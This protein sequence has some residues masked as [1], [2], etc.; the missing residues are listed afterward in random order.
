MPDGGH[1]RIEPY[2]RYEDKCGDGLFY[3]YSDF[4]D[5]VSMERIRLPGKIMREIESLGYWL[6][7][8]TPA[9]RACAYRDPF[10]RWPIKWY[11]PSAREHIA[12][13]DRLC[14]LLNEQGVDIVRMCSPKP[15][16]IIYEDG[17]QIIIRRPSAPQ[18]TAEHFSA[19][20][21]ARRRTRQFVRRLRVGNSLAR[22]LKQSASSL[23]APH[24]P[25]D[26]PPF[27]PTECRGCRRPPSRA[28]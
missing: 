8:N 7:T 4:Q 17:V 27:A 20:R 14:Q 11:K 22:R 26:L 16:S 19:L 5:L 13:A 6:E 3:I 1:Q 28:K 12:R 9:P 2:I 21:H 24:R 15:G 10:S 18:P 23:S 25:T